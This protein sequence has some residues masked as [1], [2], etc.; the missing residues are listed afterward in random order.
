MHLHMQIRPQHIPSFLVRGHVPGSCG[1]GIFVLDP[2]KIGPSLSSCHRL[3]LEQLIVT[4]G[5]PRVQCHVLVPLHA[6]SPVCSARIASTTRRPRW[7]HAFLGLSV[8]EVPPAGGGLR[9]GGCRAGQPVVASPRTLPSRNEPGGR[10]S[11]LN[12][13]WKRLGPLIV[14]NSNALWSGATLPQLGGNDAVDG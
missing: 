9:A 5:Q 14:G 13:H 1:C 2:A 12:S 10:G 4:A 8:R 3:G 6:H 7:Q 11:C